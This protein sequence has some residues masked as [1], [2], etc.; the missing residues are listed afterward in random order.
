MLPNFIL[1]K[2]LLWE[3]G[4]RARVTSGSSTL[5]GKLVDSIHW[6]CVCVPFV[7]Q[8]AQGEEEYP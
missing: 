1:T 8:G 7:A 3:L 2:I 6:Y 4:Y 5:Q